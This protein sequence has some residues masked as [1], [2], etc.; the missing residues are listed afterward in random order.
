LGIILKNSFKAFVVCFAWEKAHSSLKNPCGMFQYIKNLY[1]NNVWETQKDIKTARSL[2][3]RYCAQNYLFK[4]L[5]KAFVLQKNQLQIIGETWK[6]INFKALNLDGSAELLLNPVDAGFSKEFFIYGFREPLNTAALF[7][8]VARLK[9]TVLDVGSNLGYFPLIELEA[10]AKEVVAV[11]PVPSTFALLSRTLQRVKRVELLNIAISDREERLKLYVAAERNG[12]SSSRPFVGNSRRV[13]VEEIN[14]KAETLQQMADQYPIDMVRMDVEGHEYRIL[15][16][17][18]PDQIDCISME[19]HVIP[20]YSKDQAVGL[21]RNLSEQNF[22]ASVAIN[23]M[24]FGYYFLV[25][26]AGLELAY[27]LVTMIN[28]Q[29][30]SCPQIHTDLSFNELVSWLPE[31]CVVYLFMQR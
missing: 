25:Q 3:I 4:C 6:K 12:T 16:R 20:P 18:I 22:Q 23:G 10:G 5:R 1:G 21:L 27:K 11:E 24:S 7:S 8:C 31:P 9:P 14:V 26:H 19:L 29:A 30:P 17:K 15:G 13:I 2:G 28:A